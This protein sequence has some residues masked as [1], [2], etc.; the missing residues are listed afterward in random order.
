MRACCKPQRAVKVFCD[1][2]TW[3]LSQITYYKLSVMPQASARS[4]KVFRKMTLPDDATVSSGTTLNHGHQLVFHCFL[5]SMEPA[6]WMVNN[7]Y[8]SGVK[9]GNDRIPIIGYINVPLL[10]KKP[11]AKRKFYSR[12]KTIKKTK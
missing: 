12:K 7:R 11:Q 5:V 4:E 10:R 6:H 2:P 3:L 9:K 1:Y 8:G